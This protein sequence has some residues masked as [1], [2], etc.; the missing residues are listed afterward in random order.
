MGT[1]GVPQTVA[2]ICTHAAARLYVMGRMG[3]RAGLPITPIADGRDGRAHEGLTA[4]GGR[5]AAWGA[6]DGSKGSNIQPEK[7]AVYVY[8]IRYIALQVIDKRLDSLPI[9]PISSAPERSGAAPCPANTH[10]SSSHNPQRHVAL[11]H[12]SGSNV[13][14]IVNFVNNCKFVAWA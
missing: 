10:A 13:L 3:R 12:D 1:M 11:Q 5:G 9:Q 14:Q 8:A 2:A 7:I 6:R 4:R